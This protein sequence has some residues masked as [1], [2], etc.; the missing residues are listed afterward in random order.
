[1]TIDSFFAAIVQ[2]VG[3]A[4]DD[5]KFIRFTFLWMPDDAD[6]REMNMRPANAAICLQTLVEEVSRATRR[7]EGGEGCVVKVMVFRK[8]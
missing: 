3:V 8:G 5:I 2:A 7:G 1:M 4:R 6:E